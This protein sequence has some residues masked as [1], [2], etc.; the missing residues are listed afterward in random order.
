MYTTPQMPQEKISE[1]PK[2]FPSIWSMSLTTLKTWRSGWGI[3]SLINLGTVVAGTVVWSIIIS[4][5]PW[6]KTLL[7]DPKAIDPEVIASHYP[8]VATLISDLSIVCLVLIGFVLCIFISQIMT[9][10]AINPETRHKGLRHLF[11]HAL[12]LTPHY[13]LTVSI[14]GLVVTGGMSL[15]IIP[16]ILLIPLA[17]ATIYI[18]A[19][20]SKRG[21]DAL[22][23]GT[24]YIK[25]HIMEALWRSVVILLIIH[26]ISLLLPLI[27]TLPVYPFTLL[28][29]SAHTVKT[30]S[31]VAGTLFT[32]ITLILSVIMPSLLIIFYHQIYTHMKDNPTSA[33]PINH[34][35][36]SVLV[37]IGAIILTGMLLLETFGI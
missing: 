4:I 32:F 6:L 31:F 16:G 11:V 17:I 3:F 27:A 19:L 13:V 37:W 9:I 7:R 18:A 1:A 10:H 24:H 36:I 2:A 20:E 5:M 23:Q 26:A 30:L 33:K 35:I 22:I 15:L 8:N 25:G 12:K 21:M 34:H 14:V 28:D 29:F